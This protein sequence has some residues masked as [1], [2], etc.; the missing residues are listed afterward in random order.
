MEFAV[1]AVAHF[2]ALL[3]PGPDFF[4]IMQAS[5][6]LPVRYGIA[7]CAGIA[8]ANAIYLFV[9][10][11]GLEVVREMGWLMTLLRYLGAAYLIF[12]GV[13]LLKAPARSL[14]GEQVGDIL[15]VR[16]L[17]KQFA[18]GFLS[19]ILNPKNAIFYLALFT[20]MVSANTG[21][22]I[23]CLYAV[24]MTLVVLIWDTTVVMV[25][26]NRRIR[27]RLGRYIFWVEKISGMMLT[28]FGI[29]LPFI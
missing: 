23:R 17:G 1:I 5:L 16:H 12:L 24:W 25:I 22:T 29:L 19:A 7:I 20:V 10:I 14:G 21:L 2:L 18:V 3:S 8:V 28:F 6:R 9:A 11:S 13:L 15:A 4:L 27:T 26:G